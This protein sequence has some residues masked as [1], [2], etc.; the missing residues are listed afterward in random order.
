MIWIMNGASIAS[1][2]TFAVAPAG[3]EAI[4]LSDFTGDGKSEL[5]WYRASDRMLALEMADGTWT[6]IELGLTGALAAAGKMP[7]RTSIQTG[8]N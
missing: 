8:R 2:Q 7:T 1:S 6:E 5:L 3:F 4:A